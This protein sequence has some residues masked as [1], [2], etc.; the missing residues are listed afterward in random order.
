[1][2]QLHLITSLNR[3]INNGISKKN[4]QLK[5]IFPGHLLCKLFAQKKG[6]RFWTF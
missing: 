6:F 5:K 2:L 4:H 1:M 3:S